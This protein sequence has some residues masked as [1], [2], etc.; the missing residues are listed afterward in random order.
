MQDGPY[1][2]VR[3]PIYAGLLAMYIGS[4]AV[5][6]AW[7]ALLGLALALIAYARKVR[8]EE[9]TLIR[10]FGEEYCK[11]RRLTWALFPGFY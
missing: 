3:H 8:L 5:S 7:H 1:R 10:A 2:M 9:A 4:S 6:G 11:Y